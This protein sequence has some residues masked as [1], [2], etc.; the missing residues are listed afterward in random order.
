MPPL[1]SASPILLDQTFPRS[2]DELRLVAQSLGEL[3][4]VI[5]EDTAHLVLT[6]AMRRVVE[7]FNWNRP[8]IHSH[9]I[10]VYRLLNQLFLQTHS[11]LLRIDTSAVRDHAPHPIPEGCTAGEHID[12]WSDEMGRLLSLHDRCTSDHKMFLGVACHLAFSGNP[13]SQYSDPNSRR[14]FPLVGPLQLPTLADGYEWEAPTNIWNQ[15]VS[16]ESAKMNSCHLGAIAVE[17]PKGG[18]H[19]KVCFLGKRPWALDRNCDPV[20]ERFL[21]ELIP[22]TGYPLDVIKTVLNTGEFPKRVPKFSKISGAINT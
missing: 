3:L 9:L 16:F 4:K 8:N 6:E 18:S 13:P 7:A 17:P 10:D 20:P 15:S 5:E 2:D 12:N 22:I 11:R 1:L 21:K 14:A 19:Y